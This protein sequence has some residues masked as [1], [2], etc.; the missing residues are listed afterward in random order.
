VGFIINTIKQDLPNLSAEIVT[1]IEAA[2][3]IGLDYESIVDLVCEILEERI[4]LLVSKN[5][6]LSS[7]LTNKENSD[8][9]DS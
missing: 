7:Y 6:I 2:N 3:G 8:I 1:I 9:I 5:A 4:D